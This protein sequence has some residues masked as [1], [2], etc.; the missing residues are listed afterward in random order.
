LIDPQGVIQVAHYDRLVTDHLP[1]DLIDRFAASGAT[2]VG[3][4]QRM[5]QE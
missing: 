5:V 2:A 4:A 1:L 3:P